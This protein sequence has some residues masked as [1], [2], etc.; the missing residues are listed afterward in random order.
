MKE[1]VVGIDFS[2]GAANALE[3][4]VTLNQ[5]LN[6][7]ITMIWVDKPMAPE[8]VFDKVTGD[9]RGGVHEKFEELIAEYQPKMKSGQL[10]YK[11][12]TGKV[13]DEIAAYAKQ[14]KADYIIA[15]THGISG[16]E[17][18]WIGSNA[19]RIVSIAHCPV[20]TVR[21]NS[22][23]NKSIKKILV[24]IDSSVETSIK[25]AFAAEIA[26]ATQAEIHL[27]SIYVTNV[28]VLKRKVDEKSKEMS[29]FLS[30]AGIK[31]VQYQKLTN[32][33]TSDLLRYINEN[34]I[35]LLTIMTEQENKAADIM[36]GQYA[37]QM[38]NH[39]PVPVL[40]VHQEDVISHPIDTL[41]A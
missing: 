19:N 33:L 39:S 36:L 30:K 16:F 17:E 3:F 31:V 11:I 5:S 37:Q 18:L 12:R 15:G 4:A 28:S 2:K 8:S 35:D 6:S 10:S 38:V 27:M 13:Y 41:D 32:N 25:V 7:N 22:A 9:Y 26:K 29:D 1:I 14:H 23:F 24:P 21:Q 34:E 40:S 20:F